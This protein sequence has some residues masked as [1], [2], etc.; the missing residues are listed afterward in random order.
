MGWVVVI[1]V[2][3]F[4]AFIT[5][6][7]IIT[8]KK[9]KEVKATMDQRGVKSYFTAHHVEGL[10]IGSNALC[11]IM[12]FEDR[13]QIESGESKFQIPLSNLRAAEVK[14]EQELLEKNKSVVGRAL[15]GTLLVPGLGTIVGGMSGIGNKKK[16]GNTNTYFILNYTNSHGELAAVTFKNNFNAAGARTFSIEV[17]SAANISRSGEAILL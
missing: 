1:F 3:L 16:K 2:L 4:A 9:A 5:W 14:T 10:G 8:S 12:Q 15:I 11:D 7:I 6:M 13:I 17:N